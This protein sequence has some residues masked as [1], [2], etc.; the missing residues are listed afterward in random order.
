M[1]PTGMTV[2]DADKLPFFLAGAGLLAGSLWACLRFLFKSRRDQDSA[3]LESLMSEAQRQLRAL[4][5]SPK[6]LGYD[7]VRILLRDVQKLLSQVSNEVRKRHEPR[8]MRLLQDAARLGITL[9]PEEALQRF[10]S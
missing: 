8:A 3:R 10:P 7:Q 2:F 1:N 5:Q 6:S 9:S 4:S